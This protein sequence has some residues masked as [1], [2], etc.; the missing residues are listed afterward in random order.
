MKIDDDR[1]PVAEEERR[2]WIINIFKSPL[3]YN[4][5]EACICEMLSH[6]I[7]LIYEFIFYE[8][9]L[10]LFFSKLVSFSDIYEIDLEFCLKEERRF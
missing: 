7:Q 4:L 2:L 1:L 6:S 10:K 3:I 8:K 5:T 9:C